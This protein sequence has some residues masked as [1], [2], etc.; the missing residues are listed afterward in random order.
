MPRP[1]ELGAGAYVIKKI[2]GHEYA[3][4]ARRF[5]DGKVHFLYL[6]RLDE[7]ETLRKVIK[8]F[9]RK[10]ARKREELQRL[11][12]KLNDA[13]QRLKRVQRL[14]QQI[15]KHGAITRKQPLPKD[16]VSK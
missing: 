10:V 13:K 12:L 1:R 16:R 3:Y 5:P 9:E 2:R 7:E 4:L 15:E 11:E 6:G 14:K 8:L